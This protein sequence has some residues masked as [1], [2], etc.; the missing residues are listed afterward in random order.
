MDERKCDVQSLRIISH[1]FSLVSSDRTSV[2][3]TI[4]SK[5]KT[6][7]SNTASDTEITIV[8]LRNPGKPIADDA[9]VYCSGY[10]AKVVVWKAEASFPVSSHPRKRRHATEL[11]LPL[12]IITRPR[13]L[14]MWRRPTNALLW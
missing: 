11:P 10:G 6:H 2:V 9:H 12:A 4:T 3:N 1:A 13:D 7:S 8:P 5:S 14:F